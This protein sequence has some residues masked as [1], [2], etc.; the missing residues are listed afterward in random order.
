[1]K[2]LK[3]FI[4]CLLVGISWGASAQEGAGRGNFQNMSAEERAKSTVERLTKELSLEKAQQDSIYVLSLEQANVDKAA[5]ESANGDREKIRSVMQQNR[6]TYNTKVKKFLTD[7]QIKKYDK[8]E[9]ERS[10]R[11]PR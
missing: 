9:A 1:M 3:T 8:L 11:G 7:E 6:A 2:I 5:F 10:S 4:I